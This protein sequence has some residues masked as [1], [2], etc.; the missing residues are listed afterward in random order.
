ML[1]N[2]LYRGAD[3]IPV[4]EFVKEKFPEQKEGKEQMTDKDFLNLKPIP[5]DK[6]DK[7]YRDLPETTNF[8]NIV[9]QY[10]EE[11]KKKYEAEIKAENPPYIKPGTNLLL[12]TDYMFVDIQD[13][14]GDHSFLK[15][16]DYSAFWNKNHEALLM[17]KFYKSWRP[18]KDRDEKGTFIGEKGKYVPFDCSL[19]PLNAKVWIYIRALDKVFNITPFLE[20]ASTNKNAGVGAFSINVSPM[21]LYEAD[22]NNVINFFGAIG[23]GGDNI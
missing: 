16:Y 20:F 22:E 23:I 12:D 13:L 6:S 21:Q 14:F 8:E 19:I 3:N 9:S 15:Q 4:S 10:T 5:E 2:Y 11:E 7:T 1:Q 17:D 18:F